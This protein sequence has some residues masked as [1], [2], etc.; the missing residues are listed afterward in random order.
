MSDELIQLIS[1]A[2]LIIYELYSVNGHDNTV[3][4]RFWDAIARVAGAIANFFANL[5][6]SARLNYYEAVNS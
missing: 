2:I 5:A 1:M 3:Y 6:M 4:A